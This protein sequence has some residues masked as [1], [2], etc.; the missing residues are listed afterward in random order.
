MTNI[1]ET[2]GIPDAGIEARWI[3]EDAL[4]EVQAL[5]IAE[6]RAKHEPLQYLLGKWEFYGLDFYVGEGVLIPRADTE[7]L[8]DAVLSRCHVG[9]GDEI[10]DLCCGSGCIAV[11]LQVHLEDARVCGIELSPKAWEYA[12]KNAALHAPFMKIF[13]ANVLDPTTA[14]Q[15]HGLAAITCNPPYLTR[16]DMESLQA[17]VRHEPELALGGGDDGLR[18]YREI[19][20]LWKD[21]LRPGGMLFYE[22]GIYQAGD[23]AGILREN[24]FTQVKVIQDL[25]GIDRV[26][27]GQVPNS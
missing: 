20:A 23:V 8:V 15:F 27:C 22:V 17:E 3:C 16:E 25:N 6:R 21:S 7:T 18:Y 11:A 9:S 4:D 24:G 14:A 1:L 12:R 10:A 26:V 19:T 2:G 13:C 5:Q